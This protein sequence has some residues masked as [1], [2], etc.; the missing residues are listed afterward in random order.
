MHRTAQDSLW[1]KQRQCEARRINAQHRQIQACHELVSCLDGA[2][3]FATS[4][5]IVF[6]S[7]EMPFGAAGS[8]TMNAV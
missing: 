5:R 8:K 3:Y 4:I 6:E 7:V 1:A 2:A